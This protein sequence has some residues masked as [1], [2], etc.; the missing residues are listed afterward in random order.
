MVILILMF[1]TGCKN[2]LPFTLP[3]LPGSVSC[4][5]G[6]T[7]TSVDC[8][9]DVTEISRSINVFFNIDTCNYRLSGGIENLI[10]NKS[11]IDYRF[12][13]KE[14]IRLANFIRIE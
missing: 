8:C 9:I 14:M 10:F 13:E 3:H 7:C 2:S 12:G 6:D 11:L 1:I 5:L 4:N